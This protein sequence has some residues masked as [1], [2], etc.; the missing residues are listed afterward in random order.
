MEKTQQELEKLKKETIEL[1]RNINSTKDFTPKTSKLCDWCEFRPVCPEWSHIYKTENLPVNEF[2]NDDG[3]KL[4]NKYVA[5]QEE[6]NNF[7]KNI[8]SELEKIKEAMVKLCE[9]DGVVSLNGSDHTARIWVKNVIKLPG[10]SDT[11]RKELETIIRQC[12]LWEEMSELDVFLLSKII[13]QKQLPPIVTSMI[14]Q[15]SRRER[16]EKIY[17]KKKGEEK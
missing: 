5:L 17:L 13:E 14:L 15:F 11:G 4:V 7:S 12:G 9:R 8:D 3:V 16:I 6:R 2:L 10:K 1:I